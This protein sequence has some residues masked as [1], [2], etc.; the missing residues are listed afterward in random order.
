MTSNLR[1]RTP[2]PAALAA[3]VVTA[4]LL[5]ACTADRPETV[6]RDDLS[7]RV[8]QPEPQLIAEEHAAVAAMRDNVQ[9]AD[10]FAIV[11]NFTDL[12][13]TIAIRVEHE[14]FE[15]ASVVDARQQVGQQ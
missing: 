10:V 15:D 1:H 13:N 12:I 7:V 6:H 2:A 3:W 8:A 5:T 14:D 9:R 4:G 11:E